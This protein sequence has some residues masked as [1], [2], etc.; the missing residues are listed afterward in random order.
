MGWLSGATQTTTSTGTR[1][2]DAMAMKWADNLL[3]EI[4]LSRKDLRYKFKFRGE[5]RYVPTFNPLWW[6]ITLIAVI[7]VIC[8][9]RAF[10][11]IM[12]SL[13]G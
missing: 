5:A 4:G 11:C 1:R 3:H 9:I 10:V 13:A 7:G 2:D 12:V 6:V 8:W